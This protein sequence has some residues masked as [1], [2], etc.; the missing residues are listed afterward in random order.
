M[1]IYLRIIDGTHHDVSIFVNIFALN[2]KSLA[3]L[4]NYI[5]MD[6]SRWMH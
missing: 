1:V 4:T 2:T 3:I 5:S 6:F